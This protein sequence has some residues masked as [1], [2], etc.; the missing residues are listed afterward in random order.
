MA[1]ARR[2][3]SFVETCSGVGVAICGDVCPA[4]I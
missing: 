3:F 4:V 1:F 2:K